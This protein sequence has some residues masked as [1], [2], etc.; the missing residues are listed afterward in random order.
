MKEAVEA[1]ERAASQAAAAAGRPVPEHDAGATQRRGV[2]AWRHAGPLGGVL[3]DAAWERHRR[4][5]HKNSGG[6]V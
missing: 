4:G 1:E 3:H 6:R 2:S 5:A